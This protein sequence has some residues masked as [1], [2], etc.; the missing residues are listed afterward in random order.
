[1]LKLADSIKPYMKQLEKTWLL[2]K[3][4]SKVNLVPDSHFFGHFKTVLDV[5]TDLMSF[6]IRK[7]FDFEKHLSMLYVE[8]TPQLSA[9][10]SRC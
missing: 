1:M 5:E 6:R 4:A 8:A 9:Q 2:A 3:L 10:Y 7:P